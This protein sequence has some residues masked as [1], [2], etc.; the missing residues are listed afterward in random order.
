MDVLADVLASTR[1]GAAIYGR[2]ELRAP[3]AMRFDRTNKAGFHVVQRG[4]CWLV[5]TGR[6]EPIALAQGDV[7]MIPRGWSH[8]ISDRPAP[9][10][11][12][13]YAEVVAAQRAAKDRSPPSVVLLCGAYEF[14]QSEPHPLVALLPQVM[15]ATSLAPLGAAQR[16]SLR[17]VVELLSEEIGSGKPG[18]ETIA[19]RLVDVLFLLVLREWID[20]QPIGGAGWLG[21]LRDGN[22]QRALAALHGEPSRDWSL[23][24]LA[25][26]SRT[27]RA[28]LA[29]KFTALVGEPPL[30]YLRRWRMTL[31]AK[32]LRERDVSLAE[33]ASELGYQSDAAFHKAFSRER[34]IAPG[35]YRRRFAAA[36]R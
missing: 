14:D 27:S 6:A 7:A 25:K 21:A 33:L 29:R 36:V 1:V 11:G 12:A 9:P 30:A 28:T 34:G 2:V 15:H 16:S 32:T 20:R 8:T 13:H 5:P 22:T 26:A 3:F 19:R 18:A 35:E 4:A 24:T 31:A 23:E 10:K 17:P